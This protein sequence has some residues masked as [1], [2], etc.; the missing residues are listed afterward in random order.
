MDERVE[1]RR[2]DRE[3][4]VL[5]FLRRIAVVSLV[6]SVALWAVPRLLVEAGVM[7]PTAQERIDEAARAIAT[8]RAYGGGEGLAPLKAAEDEIA[9]ARA[10]AQ[11]GR[12]RDARRAALRATT[13]AIEAQKMALVAH[14]EVRQ[15]A[16]TVY[17]DLDRQINDLEKLYAEVT[18]GLEKEQ[19]ARLLSLMKV[20]RQSTGLLFLAYEQKDYG[21]VVEREGRAREAVESARKTL[22]SSRRR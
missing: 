22:Q 3:K 2:P 11:E 5:R 19:V 15:Q 8:A 1:R 14:T 7:G 20:T 21:T 17:N 4:F 16:E 6:L 18:P 12:E 9:R 10:L 13:N